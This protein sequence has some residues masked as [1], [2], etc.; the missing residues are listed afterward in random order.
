MKKEK[1]NSLQTDSAETI[2]PQAA[3]NEKEA[4]NKKPKK[5]KAEKPKKIKA[6]KPEKITEKTVTDKK[7]K[8]KKEKIKYKFA[9]PSKAEKIGI[10]I[11]FSAIILVVGLAIFLGFFLYLV[12]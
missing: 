8:P 3:E 9:S 10:A 5:V 1:L 2:Q 11:V 12:Y 7:A 6:E 4:K